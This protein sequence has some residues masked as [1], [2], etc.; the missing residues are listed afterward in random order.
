MTLK[1]KIITN[2]LALLAPNQLVGDVDWHRR[3]RHL[4]SVARQEFQVVGLQV[5]QDLWQ[6]Q[7]HPDLTANWHCV[8]FKAKDAA[9][10]L[11]VLYEMSGLSIN[12]AR[13]G[14]CSASIIS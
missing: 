12:C 2:A 1:C 10:L 5:S 9:A 4:V 13:V 6:V 3:H 8:I 14:L 11:T 7:G